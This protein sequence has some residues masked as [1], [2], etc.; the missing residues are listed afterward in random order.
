VDLLIKKNF[1]LHHRKIGY[2]QIK[3]NLFRDHK[4]VVNHKKIKRSMRLQGLF[5]EIRRKKPNYENQYTSK[6]ERAFEN[7][8]DQNY[9]I[10]KADKV[11]SGDVTEVR[12]KSSQKI[13]MHMVKDL[14]TKEIVSFNVSANPDASL[15]LENFRLHLLGIP[16]VKL[17]NLIYHTDQGG[18]FMSDPHINL[19]QKLKVTQSMSRRGS[20]LDNA[21][22][23]SFFGHM[24]DYVDFKSSKN[25]EEI[26]IGVEKY[27][28]YYNYDRPQWNL[29]KMTPA[30]YRSHL[31]Y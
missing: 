14:G 1:E 12:L 3:M 6:I 2:R 5:C 19:M 23:E 15:V 17:Q 29:K 25:I 20:C 31:N 28:N 13:Y 16:K 24:K 27:V 7:K 11:Y 18:G 9:E 21:P 30:E 8:L 4:L 22:I 10:D 26:K